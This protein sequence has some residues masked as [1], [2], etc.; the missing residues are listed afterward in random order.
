MGCGKS[1][2]SSY[3]AAPFSEY[4]FVRT[5]PTVGERYRGTRDPVSRVTK[6]RDERQAQLEGFY[7]SVL[8]PPAQRKALQA[9]FAPFE[10]QLE[11]RSLLELAAE[12][13]PSLTSFIVRWFDSF[14]PANVALHGLLPIGQ[15]CI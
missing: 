11:S 3:D 1:K 12:L 4:I 8:L 7:D 9:K 10:E 14:D 2:H 6:T 5:V 13:D 15:L